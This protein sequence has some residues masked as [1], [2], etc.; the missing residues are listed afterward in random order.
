MVRFHAAL[1]MTWKQGAHPCVST[2]RSNPR[3]AKHNT[4]AEGGNR[5][6]AETARPNAFQSRLLRADQGQSVMPH[7][8]RTWCEHGSPAP[9]RGAIHNGDRQFL[10]TVWVVPRNYPCQH[11]WRSSNSGRTAGVGPEN[12]RRRRGRAPTAPSAESGNLSPVPAP[13]SLQR[14]PLSPDR[15]WFAFL[16]VR[17][18]RMGLLRERV[19]PCIVP[20]KRG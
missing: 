2:G 10:G 4:V 1:G 15:R 8:P 20:L 17:H 5:G 6:W 13:P 18:C 11:A 16:Q 14:R 9:P 19:D 7:Q 12:G 3:R